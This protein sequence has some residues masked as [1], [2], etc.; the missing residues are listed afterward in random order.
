MNWEPKKNHGK[1]K[2]Q[3]KMYDFYGQLYGPAPQPVYPPA[4]ASGPPVPY[5]G[6]GFNPSEGLYRSKD[7]FPGGVDG[8]RLPAVDAGWK[9][10]TVATGTR[11]S[12][13]ELQTLIQMCG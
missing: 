10:D 11:E 12:T 4:G 2:S 1:S 5:V 6:F 3:G 9:A 8:R 7:P 13:R